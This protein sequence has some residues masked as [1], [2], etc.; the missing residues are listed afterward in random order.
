VAAATVM[1]RRYATR[2]DPT[3]TKGGEHSA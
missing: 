3:G 1:A 2:E